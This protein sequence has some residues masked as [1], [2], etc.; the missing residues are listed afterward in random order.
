MY[1]LQICEKNPIAKC[2]VTNK[3]SMKFSYG[4]IFKVVQNEPLLAHYTAFGT[5][6]IEDTVD[7]QY[8]AD[9]FFE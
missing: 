7:R 2:H 4:E 3:V 6:C 1:L 5:P 9:A 8:T